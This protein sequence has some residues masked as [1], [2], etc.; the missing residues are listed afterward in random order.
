MLKDT[1]I[2]PKKFWD[3]FDKVVHELSP[4]NNELIKTREAATK[5]IDNWHIENKGNKIEINVYKK[6]LKEI[7]YLKDEGPD[8]KIQTKKLMK[9]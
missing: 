8:F 3:G 1:E 5:K 2:S 6:F 9:K 7:G 4:K